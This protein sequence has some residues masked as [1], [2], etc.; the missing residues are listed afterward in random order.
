MIAIQKIAITS[1]NNQ[2]NESKFSVITACQRG[3]VAQG[4]SEDG[5]PGNVTLKYDIEPLPGDLQSEQR[6]FHGNF[7]LL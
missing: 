5:K 4:A 2:R 3:N 7:Q 6:F 1:C